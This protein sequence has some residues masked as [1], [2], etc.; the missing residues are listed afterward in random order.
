MKCPQCQTEASGAYCPECGAPLEGARC[1][2]CDGVLPPGARYC[3]HCGEPVHALPSRLPWYI[4]GVAIAALVVAL[5]VPHLGGNGAPPGADGGQFSA[6]SAPAAAGAAAA[7]GGASV[8]GAPAGMGTPPPLTGTPRE[9]ADRLYNRIMTDQQQGNEQQ[10]QFF[11]P[12]G[13]AAYQ[14]VPDLNADGLYHLS[15]LQNLAGRS[16]AALATAKKVL[17]QQP[18]HLLALGAA[19]EAAAKAGD[20][21]AERT[22]WRRFLSAY[23][24][25]MANPLP[26][27]K[28]HAQVLPEY[29]KEAQSFL[30]G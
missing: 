23:D 14:Q 8:S 19:A 5:V 20:K 26:E 16:D 12:M 18:D 10:V 7:G 25:Q 13:I 2:Y 6:Q 29:K 30:G 17:D 27:Y 3:T 4:A 24:K 11:L 15:L 21:T 9:Q 28:E 1:E 22:Y